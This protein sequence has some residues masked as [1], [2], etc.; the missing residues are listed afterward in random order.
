[1][2]ATAVAAGA[3]RVVLPGSGGPG[4]EVA[5]E[6]TMNRESIR[7]LAV[8]TAVAKAKAAAAAVKIML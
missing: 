3:T 6:F 1:M 5:I 7:R 8:E 2:F 4:K